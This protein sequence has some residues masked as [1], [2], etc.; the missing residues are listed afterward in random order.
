MLDT[1]QPF[2]VE[3]VIARMSSDLVSERHTNMV[4]VR[5]AM[6]DDLVAAMAARTRPVPRSV[7]PEETLR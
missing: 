2:V 7:G 5:L 4:I 1:V 6:G 3:M